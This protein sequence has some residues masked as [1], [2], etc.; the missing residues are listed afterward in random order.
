[1]EGL[2]KKSIRKKNGLGELKRCRG[3]EG[4]EVKYLCDCNHKLPSAAL[5]PALVRFVPIKLV[6]PFAVEKGRN[7]ARAV[8]PNPP[9]AS[10]EPPSKTL[11]RNRTRTPSGRVSSAEIVGKEE[12][13]GAAAGSRGADAPRHPEAGVQLV[14]RRPRHL[15]LHQGDHLT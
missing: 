15:L 8:K 3:V 4:P 5:L 11:G 14:G 2:N 6:A 13:G 1:L 9:P 10:P 7:R 12:D